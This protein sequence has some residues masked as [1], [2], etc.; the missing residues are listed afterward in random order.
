MVATAWR[1]F[2]ARVERNYGGEE[3]V[4]RTGEAASGPSMNVCWMT[5][6]RATSPMSGEVDLVLDHE[7]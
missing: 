2:L 7:D 1:P 6:R 5:T 4:R 3:L